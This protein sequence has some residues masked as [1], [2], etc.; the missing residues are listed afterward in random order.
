MRAKK[1]RIAA[2]GASCCLL[3]VLGIGATVFWPAA[4]GE[5]VSVSC[6]EEP[7]RIRTCFLSSG[8]EYVQEP[9]TGL[10]PGETVEREPA[11]VLDEASPEAYLRVRVTFGG[12]LEEQ[13]SESREEQRER[14]ERIREL[15]QGI[16]FCSGWLEGQDGCMYYQKKAAPGAAVPVYD[17]VRIP[18]NWD[19]EIA[20]QVF[21][22]ELTAEAVR[23]EHLEPWLEKGMEI[24]SWE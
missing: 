15:Q 24:R 6:M 7:V 3:L 20:E 10:R 23:A 19:N 22:I 17:Q 16:R 12:V 11:V 8:E 4:Q 18:D 5:P 14:L 21:T 1:R 9:L 13:Q 2:A